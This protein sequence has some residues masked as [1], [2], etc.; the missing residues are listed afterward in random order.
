MGSTGHALSPTGFR[1][2][3]NHDR[4]AYCYSQ[5]SMVL[6]ASEDWVGCILSIRSMFIDSHLS[7]PNCTS[8][9][10]EQSVRSFAPSYR[11]TGPGESMPSI[12]VMVQVNCVNNS[13]NLKAV[14]LFWSQIPPVLLNNIVAQACAPLPTTTAQNLKF[15]SKL[16]LWCSTYIQCE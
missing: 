9:Y 1:N 15:F 5:S 10:Q 12:P 7:G 4:S 8:R 11:A 6:A 14:G 16:F 3:G 2:T 13:S